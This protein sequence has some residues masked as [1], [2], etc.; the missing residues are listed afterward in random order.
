MIGLVLNVFL[1]TLTVKEGIFKSPSRFGTMAQVMVRELVMEPLTHC[2]FVCWLGPL[3][4]EKSLNIDLISTF[5]K[6]DAP[7][8][9]ILNVIKSSIE[10]WSRSTD[11]VTCNANIGLRMARLKIS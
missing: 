1:L 4:I 10:Q 5:G 3:I 8:A 9:S 11:A 2:I 7:S 6:D